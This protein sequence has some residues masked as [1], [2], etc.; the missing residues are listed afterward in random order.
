MLG[1]QI[2]VKTASTYI[3]NFALKIIWLIFILYVF[4]FNCKDEGRSQDISDYICENGTFK[5]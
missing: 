5:V 3:W 1:Y 2:Q 4:T